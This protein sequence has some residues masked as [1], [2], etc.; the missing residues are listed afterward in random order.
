MHQAEQKP[1]A[2]TLAAR[3][4]QMYGK[5]YFRVS[6]LI[7]LIAIGVG[8]PMIDILLIIAGL[9]ALFFGLGVII[10]L[11]LFYVVEPLDEERPRLTGA[12][13]AEMSE[14]LMTS[15][16][17]RQ[18]S[19]E[20]LDEGLLELGYMPRTHIIEEGP[21][22]GKFDERPIYDWVRAKVGAKGEVHRYDFLRRATLD[23]NKVA[24]VENNDTDIVL[25]TCVYRRT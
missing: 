15:W 19:D 7:L 24:T 9:V 6:A 10:G 3:A 5:I 11:W 8:L 22:I 21:I 23:E 16:R 12:Q 17:N 18:I 2:T 4:G 13:R 20:D 1:E 14:V 25:N